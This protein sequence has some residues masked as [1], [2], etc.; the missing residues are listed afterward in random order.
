AEALG[1]EE[2]LM[3]RLA[4]KA[5]NLVLD[6]RAITRTDPLDD[7]G[8]HRRAIDRPANNLVRALVG[9]RDPARQLRGMHVAP[10]EE[11][12]HRLRAVTGLLGQHAEIDAAAIEARRRAGFEPSD[13]QLQLAQAGGQGCR[14]RVAGAARAVALQADVDQPSEE[15]SGGQHD[16]TAAEAHAE[17]RHYTDCAIA[18]EH[19]VVD[20]LLE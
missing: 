20:R 5:M 2:D 17:L 11:G 10:A 8:K 19:D 9:M 4:G 13:R 7:A 12:K 16:G 6:R 14:R 15:S 18:L 1:L 3:A